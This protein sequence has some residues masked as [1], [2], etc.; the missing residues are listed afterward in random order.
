MLST[1]QQFIETQKKVEK[2]ASNGGFSLLSGN[3]IIG[4][5]DFGFLA[6][7]L[8]YID[9]K[10]H[11]PVYKFFWQTAIPY[12]V[13]GGAMDYASF[14]KSNYSIANVNP[15]ASG[16]NNVLIT[17][18]AQLQKYST[19]VA[20]FTY[21]LEIGL[22]DE[23]KA[24]KIGYNILDE[25]QEGILMQHNKMMDRVTFFGLPN[26]SESYGY[27]NH[28][29]VE[30]IEETDTAWADMDAVT[31]FTKINEVL[32]KQVVASEYA[33]D[34]VANRIHLP[35]ALFGKL[36]LPMA[37]SGTN[38]ASATTG[39]S[40]Y[41]YL[42]DNLAIALAGYGV[43]EISLVVNRYLAN[44]GTNGTGRI[45]I[46]RYNEDI[47]RGI[48]GMDLTRGATVFD[49]TSQSTKTTY[50]AFVGEPQII[51]PIAIKYYDNK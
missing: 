42:K 8:E 45:V 24:D 30:V 21:I 29:D 50:M 26:D 49:A 23:M 19:K 4:D 3:N 40:L 20:A 43:G 1:K 6:N 2:M 33:E 44:I 5:S 34:F 41:Q 17:A 36:A 39:V 35:L 25:F 10:L 14:Y 47:A 46:D 38:G 27:F 32:I 18:K 9:T 7:A 48:L 13:V 37:I 51:R 16:S 22:I 31:F 15:I 12:K 11:R 28:P